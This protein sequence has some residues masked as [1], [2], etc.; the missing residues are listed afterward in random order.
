[1]EANEN[2]IRREKKYEWSSLLYVLPVI[3][4]LVFLDFYP[5][6]DSIYFSL[7]NFG[8]GIGMSFYNPVFIGSLNY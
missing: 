4:V 5:I 6:L 1:M 2:G 7:T 8:V 3:A